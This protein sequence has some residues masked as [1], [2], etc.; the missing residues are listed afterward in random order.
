MPKIQFTLKKMEN[1]LV[2]QLCPQKAIKSVF[3]SE[4]RGR[5]VSTE[6]PAVN[7]FTS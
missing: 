6:P 2:L 5:R 3:H 1:L 4:L 7:R